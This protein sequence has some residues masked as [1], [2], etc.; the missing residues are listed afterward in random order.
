M[1]NVKSFNEFINESKVYEKSAAQT[2]SENTNP[3]AE[4]VKNFNFSIVDEYLETENCEIY[5]DEEVKSI[6]KFGRQAEI[7]TDDAKECAV[8]KAIKY[9]EE[10]NLTIDQFGKLVDWAN[11][12]DDLYWGSLVVRGAVQYNEQLKENS[13]FLDYIKKWY[14]T[15]N[16]EI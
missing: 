2:I 3:V 4:E 11:A 9:S 10:N 8:Y 12:I 6:F 1:K 15:Y 13:K 16:N 5:P 7:P 14:D